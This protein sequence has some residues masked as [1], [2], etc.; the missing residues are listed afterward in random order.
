MKIYTY[1]NPD[2]DTVL[3]QPVDEHSI[4]GLE[5]EINLIEEYTDYCDFR[6][7][8]V[9]VDDW[10]RDLSPWEAPA[11]F[12]DEG[13]GKDA[14]KTLDFIEKEIVASDR[15]T[16]TKPLHYYLGGYSLAGLFS[17]WAGCNTDVFDGI[18]AVSPSVW[19]PDFLPYIKSEKILTRAVYLSLGKKEEKVKNPVMSKVGDAI[20]E[21]HDH[22][23]KTG[24]STTLEWNDGNHFTEPELRMAK[25][26]SWVMKN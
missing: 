25:G 19:F 5:Q 14:H 15:N 8:A 9:K 1:G 6:M 12:G 11:V 7:I 13:F 3:I 10:N 24:I 4:S 2:V 18:A 20:R 17:L 26:F 16:V 23:E 21:L 22:L